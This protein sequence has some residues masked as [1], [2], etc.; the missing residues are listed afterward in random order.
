ML[1][2]TDKILKGIRPNDWHKKNN[3][4][5]SG[6]PWQAWYHLVEQFCRR[7]LKCKKSTTIGDLSWFLSRL[8]LW[9]I[10]PKYL[11]I[12]HNCWRLFQKHV[13]HSTFDIYIFTTSNGWKQYKISLA[14]N[15]LK[16]C[17]VIWI[18]CV[19]LNELHKY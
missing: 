18:S 2:R 6:H 5:N 12:E 17:I 14:L 19:T 15:E 11:D 13:V 3:F 16:M 1:F 9:F 8:D 7:K 4:K 10:G